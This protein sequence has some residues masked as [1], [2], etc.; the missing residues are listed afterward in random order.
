MQKA[1]RGYRLLKAPYDRSWSSTKV[2]TFW[3]KV[4]SAVAPLRPFPLAKVTNVTLASEFAR[5]VQLVHFETVRGWA[6]RG[7]AHA[8]KAQ[9][10][11]LSRCAG[12]VIA[13]SAAARQSSC[14]AGLLRYARNDEQG[15]AIA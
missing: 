15:V 7:R 11:Q 2:T 9:L 4:T 14:A 12:I 6:L 5:L 13:S 3:A 10:W 8:L 1:R